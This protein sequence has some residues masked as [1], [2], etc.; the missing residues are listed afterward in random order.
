MVQWTNCF[1]VVPCGSS[2]KGIRELITAILGM[3]TLTGV[4]LGGGGGGRF[5]QDLF[6]SLPIVL[7]LGKLDLGAYAHQQPIFTVQ[8]P[9]DCY[10]PL[11]IA[12][13]RI[14][15]TQMVANSIF[16]KNK[17]LYGP[18]RARLNRTGGYRAQ[19]G[20]PNSPALTVN[21]RKAM[22]VTG[23]ATQGYYGENIQE[24][25]KGYNLGY[26]F[27]SNTHFFKERN[28]ITTKVNRQYSFN[29]GRERAEC[30]CGL[31]FLST[32]RSKARYRY[33]SCYH[34]QWP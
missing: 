29:K 7:T 27:G 12:D 13:G 17:T 22:I 16:N 6:T 5:F 10:G 32:V 9:L 15:E 18:G 21:F 19:P 26:T 25:T 11:G 28:R 2:F 4:G 14:N 34:P 30:E 24:W 31:A 3:R 20:S 1:D 8:F 23:I 33:K